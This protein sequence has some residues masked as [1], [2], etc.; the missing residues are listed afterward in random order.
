MSSRS[1]PLSAHG[2][3]EM[4]AA[5]AIMAA[6]FVLGFGLAPTVVS[7]GVGAAMLALALQ[8]ESPSRAVPLAAHA[9]FEYAIAIA[10]ALSG[11]AIGLLSGEWY[12]TIFLAGIGAAQVALTASTRFSTARSV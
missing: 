1:I 10:A 9:G 8:L 6:P 3:L 2:A 11:V 4:F 7:V 12:A 5:P